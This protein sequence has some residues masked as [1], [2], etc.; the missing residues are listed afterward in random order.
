[1]TKSD[2]S[3]FWVEEERKG[4]AIVSIGNVWKKGLLL[5]ILLLLVLIGSAQAENFTVRVE[6]DIIGFDENQ[7]TVETDQ[8][9]LLTLTLSDNYGTYRTITREAKR[10]VT[11]FMW[12][13][14]GENEERLPSGSYT[15]HAL[16][17]TARG[18]QETQINVTVG[19]A[20][21]ALL[22]ALRSSDTLYLDTDDW[23]CEAKPVRTG[24]VVMDIYAADDLN[25][26]LDT[27]KKT[28]GSTTK[29]SWNGRV[30]GKK[31][32]EGDYLL[33][34]YAESNPAYV[35]DVRVT[36]KEGAR[37]VIPVAETGSIMPTWD[38]DDAAMWD[39]MMKPSVGVDIAAVSHQKVYDK[40]ST[41]GKALGTLHGQSQGVEVLKVEGGWAYIGAWQHESGGYIEGWVPMKRLKTVTPNSDFGL[42]VDKQMQRMKVFYRG[43]CITTLT[44]STGLAG[45]NRLIRETAAGAFI[46]VERVS[47][48][49]DSGYHYEYAT[50][51]SLKI[52][53]YS[54]E[55]P[56]HIILEHPAAQAIFAQYAPEFLSNPMLEYV[57]NE[58]VT[59]L[60]AYG[61]SIKPLFE[62][63]LAAMNQADKE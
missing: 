33:R 58:P 2:F 39:M 54:L 45:K 13:G 11:T 3:G 22:F 49:E 57:K 26:K 8:T 60:L 23:F 46:T 28:F 15:L 17:V 59:A 27:L 52:D 47:D 1:M 56:L 35:R 42:V 20:K 62:Q 18:N 61:D 53:R 7:I 12:D 14:L 16:L 36:V 43:K 24:A 19:K 37:P 34:F 29:V 4:D 9:G 48:F 50:E 25:T 5:G 44:I 31:V 10:G 40:P 30:K 41:N 55:T 38:M 21:Q 32:A 6:K 63:V 51:T